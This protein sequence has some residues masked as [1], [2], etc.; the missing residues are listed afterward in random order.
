[1]CLV[2]ETHIVH[3]PCSHQGL[4]SK[5]QVEIDI[6]DNQLKVYNVTNAM[7]THHKVIHK[8]FQHVQHTKNIR[9]H[10]VNQVSDQHIQL[11]HK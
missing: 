4:R 11:I 8:S 1:M 3:A 7:S 10:Q 9:Q 5:T 6:Q 2:L